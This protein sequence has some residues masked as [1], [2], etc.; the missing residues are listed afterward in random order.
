MT[1]RLKTGKSLPFFSS[2]S[3]LLVFTG[4]E[5]WGLWQRP[6][7]VSCLSWYL[8]LS[9]LHSRL[10]QW[11]VQLLERPNPRRDSRFTLTR[12]IPYAA[13]SHLSHGLSPL[14]ERHEH[15]VVM[16]MMACTCLSS[17]QQ[18]IETTASSD[19][20]TTAERK[21][22]DGS[23]V[24]HHHQSDYLVIWKE[25]LTQHNLCFNPR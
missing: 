11:S 23:V 15:W 9:L 8:S 6:Q 20:V 25:N 17:Q 5:G 3:T 18:R 19:T 4:G 16:Y 1:S 10:E 24:I 14:S 22:C 12:K 21:F 7:D 2:V 13:A